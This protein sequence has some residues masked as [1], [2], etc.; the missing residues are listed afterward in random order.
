MANAIFTGGAES[1]VSVP[2]P[3]PNGQSMV[4]SSQ[5]G[6][7]SSSQTR[8]AGWPAQ[9][10][11]LLLALL[12]ALMLYGVASNQ[13]DAG[14]P[15]PLAGP[16]DSRDADLYRDVAARVGAGEGYYQTAVTLHRE[17]NYPLRP[18]FTVR[19]PTLAWLTGTFGPGGTA[20]LHRLLG[21]A[22]I[23][24]FALRIRRARS[25][26]SEWM[27][28]IVLGTATT[29]L[30][31]AEDVALWHESWAGLLIL[32]SLCCRSRSRW[33]ISVALGLAAVLIRELALPYLVVML[34]IAWRERTYHEAV[35]WALAATVALAALT[36]HAANVTALTSAADFHS[37]GWSTFGGLSHLVSMVRLCTPLI[38]LP[39]PAVA[40]ILPLAFL[41]WSAER[42]GLGS[43]VFLL[44]AGYS[45]AFMV[46]GR[47]ENFYW[48]LII[49]PVLIPGLAFAPR[50]LRDLAIAA[51]RRARLTNP[52]T[53]EG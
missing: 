28:A 29:A 52:R 8:F 44:I 32:L 22:A 24:A 12:L 11:R 40:A 39:P 14:A 36:V 47:P 51:S 42:D 27:A 49:A 34:V 17:R 4:H 31:V 43:R 25:W 41:G 6:R 46:V 48:G 15:A 20:L 9:R 7:E 1:E 21:L 19:L 45:A 18:F 26:R 30:L 10:A 33:A 23:G 38:L 5:S 2:V 16:T 37:Q 3:A 35:A 50:A 13:A 53:A